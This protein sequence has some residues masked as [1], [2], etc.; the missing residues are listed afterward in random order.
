MKSWN[1]ASLLPK[2]LLRNFTWLNTFMEQM[3]VGQP[4]TYHKKSW[5][6]NTTEFQKSNSNYIQNEPFYFHCSSQDLNKQ[7]IKSL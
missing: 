3:T 7:L 1:V 2:L 5:S 6:G 4:N